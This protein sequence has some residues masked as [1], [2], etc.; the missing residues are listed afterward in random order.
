MAQDLW[1]SS[2]LSS[3]QLSPLC[4]YIVIA[5]LNIFGLESLSLSKQ[6]EDSSMEKKWWHGKVAYQIYPKSFCDS[7]GDGVGDIQGIISKLDYLKDLGVEIV[8]LSPCFKSPFVD[9]GYDISDYQDIDPIFGTMEDF[10]ELLAKA[11]ERGISIILDLVINHCSS[12]HEWFKKACADPNC[13][14]AKYF[15]IKKGKDGKVPDNLRSYFGGSVW[16]KLPGHED[17]DLYY[18]HYFA[19]QQPDLN[20]YYEPLRENLFAMINFWLDKGV[21]G[22]R[23]DAIMNIAKDLSFPG[24]PAD[25]ADGMCSANKMTAKLSDQAATFLYEMNDKTF[26]PHD[27]LSVAEAFGVNQ[28]SLANY[29]GDN[30]FFS[31]IFDFSARELNE[32]YPAYYRYRPVTIDKWREAVFAAQNRANPIGFLCPIIE[33]HDEPRGVSYYLPTHARTPDGAKA[34]AAV[35]V[36][37]RG[38]PFIYQGQE[39]GMTNTKFNSIYEFDDL[40]AKDNYK[41]ALEAGLT[42]TQALDILNVESRDHA[43]TPMLWDDSK[44]AGFSSAAVT[45]LKVHQDYHKLNVAA[46]KD[47]P[48]SVL[49][50]YK[51]L[52]ALRKSPEFKELFTYG[53]FQALDPVADYVVPFARVLD[54]KT[55]YVIANFEDSSVSYGVNADSKILL[56]SKE[57]QLQDGTL[58]IPAVAC[59]VVAL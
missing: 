45:W 40:N 42:E 11:K 36:L 30:G 23:V 3:Q 28:E 13:E 44:N 1:L 43:R 39:I 31:T 53:D 14:E 5:L 2:I 20:W 38:I 19:K 7:N 9:Q 15:F 35:N 22:F 26:K 16:E 48:N 51:Q 10:D 34:F 32:K 41:V 33:N 49:S 8:W 59:V 25:G 6:K 54:G 55:I 58:T 56:S 18:L 50:F 37:L 21:A 29:I 27:G 4:P 17:E 24:L 47:D 46:Q 52:I 57:V 12:E